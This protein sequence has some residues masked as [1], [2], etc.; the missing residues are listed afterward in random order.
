MMSPQLAQRKISAPSRMLSE[1]NGHRMSRQDEFQ[2]K[3]EQKIDPGMIPCEF[4]GD[5]Q[6]EETIMRHQVAMTK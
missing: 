5:M 6:Y 1:T 3:K 2:M 4:C